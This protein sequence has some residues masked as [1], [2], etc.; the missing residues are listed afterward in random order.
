MGWVE[1]GSVGGAGMT[2]TACGARQVLIPGSSANL[3]RPS[4]EAGSV[5]EKTQ[6]L[7]EPNHCSSLNCSM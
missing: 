6:S 2:S 1:L 7:N 3:C 4:H 5:L